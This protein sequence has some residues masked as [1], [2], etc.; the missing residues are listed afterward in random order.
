[1]SPGRSFRN[2]SNTHHCESRVECF[3]CSGEIK[4]RRPRYAHQTCLA[5]RGLTLRACLDAKRH[6]LLACFLVEA[7]KTILDH[8]I[9]M[10]DQ[11]LT[12][13]CRRS[14]SA[15]QTD[16]IDA[17]QRARRGNEQVLDAMESGRNPGSV[18]QVVQN[19]ERRRRFPIQ[20]WTIPNA[21]L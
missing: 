17:R 16:V 19:R 15:Y 9:E 5:N 2:Y 13:M 1:M 7:L 4:R 21:A 18:R 20:N 3:F 12:G 6:A 10:N 8:A 14:E 11:Y